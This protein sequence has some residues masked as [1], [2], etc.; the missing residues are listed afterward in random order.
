[1][2]GSSRGLD[3]AVSVQCRRV[4]RWCCPEVG[5]L[6]ANVHLYLFPNH[7]FIMVLAHTKIQ[8]M[9]LSQISNTV[10]QRT[11]SGATSTGPKPS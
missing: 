2:N 6:D 11:V 1:M 3:L 7:I 5:S 8:R 10:F 9:L 4:S